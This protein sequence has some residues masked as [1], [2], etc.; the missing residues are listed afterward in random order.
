MKKLDCQGVAGHE[1]AHWAYSPLGELIQ[2]KNK[3]DKDPLW[4]KIACSWI[5]P[6]SKT[7]IHPKVMY[8]QSYLCAMIEQERINA[9]RNL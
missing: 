6:D 9:K 3:K 7:Y 8:K 1:G 4:K 2:W 5:P